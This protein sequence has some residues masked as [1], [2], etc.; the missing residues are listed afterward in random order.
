MAING[1]LIAV[2]SLLATFNI[3][4]VCD[5]GGAPALKGASMTPGLLS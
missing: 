4:Q 3:E 1:T 5:A 2:A